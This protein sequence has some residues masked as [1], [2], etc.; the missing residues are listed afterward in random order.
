MNRRTFFR[1]SIAAAALAVLPMYAPGLGRVR[2]REEAPE[3]KDGDVLMYNGED[4][5]EMRMT[6]EEARAIADRLQGMIRANAEFRRNPDKARR[7]IVA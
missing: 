3:P 6:R 7:S 5:L 1:R 2:V 4:I